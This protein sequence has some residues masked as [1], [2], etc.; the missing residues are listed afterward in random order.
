M[1]I[2]VSIVN[3]NSSW[4]LTGRLEVKTNKFMRFSNLS[5]HLRYPPYTVTINIHNNIESK[6]LRLFIIVFIAGKKNYN[7][8]NLI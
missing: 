2:N 8:V 3:L 5:Y 1:R 7:Y 4:L 6:M